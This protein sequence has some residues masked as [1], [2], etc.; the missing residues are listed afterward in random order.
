MNWDDFR[1]VRAIA[2]AKS[3][4]GAA[5]SLGLNHSTVFRRL[6]QIEGDLGR[7]LFERS[8]SG[9]AATSAGEEMVALANRMSDG[10]LEFERRLAGQDERPRGELRVTTT[11]SLYSSLLA[12][13]IADFLTAYP[14]ISVEIIVSNAALNLSRRDADVAIR[15][16]AEPPDTLIGR[17]VGSMAWGVYAKA[18]SAFA[19]MDPLGPEALYVGFASPMEELAAAQW[20]SQNVPPARVVARVN[21]MHI[22]AVSAAAGIGIAVV[23]RVVGDAM[24]DLV[25]LDVEIPTTSALWLLTHADLKGAARVRAFMDHVWTQLSRE[26]AR[27][28]GE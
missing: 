3:L 22:A 8:R 21:T 6:G 11:D 16:T 19:K 27:L 24:P 26:R 2:E 25:R 5:D 18:G 13:M 14:E 4:V 1:L 23:P 9:Y 12:P 7:S 20:I 10:V 17:K 15:A 28:T